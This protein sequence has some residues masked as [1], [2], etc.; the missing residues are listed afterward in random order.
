MDTQ[1]VKTN[2]EG[3]YIKPGDTHEV[4]GVNYQAELA[5]PADTCKGCVGRSDQKLCGKLPPCFITG[6]NV[7][8][9]VVWKEV[10]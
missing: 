1:S 5:P 3:F 9:G 7:P 10:K 6:K 2:E 4:E 8:A